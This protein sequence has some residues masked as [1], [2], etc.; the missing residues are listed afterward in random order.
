M[1]YE[2]IRQQTHAA[3]VANP[4]TRV[5]GQPTF[6]QKEAF[7]SE[8][9]EVALQFTVSY[10]WAGEHGLLA[11]VAGATKYLATTGKAYVAPVRPLIC[12][13]RILGGTLNQATI[14]VATAVNDTAKVDFAVLEGYRSGFS[15]NFRWAFDAKY[16][17]QLWEE[18]FKYKRIPPITFITHL[19]TRHVTLDTMV[20]GQLKSKYFRG[21]DGEEHI[22]SFGI[23]LNREQ[24]KLGS[25]NPSITIS[26]ED[27]NQHYL[28]QM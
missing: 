7:I 15:E 21:W 8:C 19:E 18:T 28:E 27:K 13:P 1:D 6:E 24:R 10:P 12:D 26:D 3:V 16:Y 9:E 25:Y 17:E 11:E 20:I 2:S 4:F 22:N 5:P 23:R 14:R